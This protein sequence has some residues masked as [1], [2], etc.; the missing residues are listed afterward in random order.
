M[1]YFIYVISLCSDR[2]RVRLSLVFALPGPV[3][4]CLQSLHCHAPCSTV[5]SLCIAR[6]LVRLLLVFALPGPVFDS[7]ISLCISR[8]RIRVSVA[9][10]EDNDVDELL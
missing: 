6:P 5:I 1:Q 4:D 9:V 3:F 8:P 10:G 7:I 2:P